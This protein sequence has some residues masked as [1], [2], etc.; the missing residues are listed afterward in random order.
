MVLSHVQSWK[1]INIRA[2]LWHTQ[3]IPCS[4]TLP[5][6]KYNCVLIFLRQMYWLC[7]QIH[8]PT[9]HHCKPHHN[10]LNWVKFLHRV[11]AH[12]EGQVPIFKKKKRNKCDN[13]PL[14]RKLLQIW[15]S[16]INSRKSWNREIVYILTL[17]PQLVAT[18]QRT[19]WLIFQIQRSEDNMQSN[20]Q[21]RM[22]KWQVSRLLLGN[23]HLSDNLGL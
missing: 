7:C 15:R 1:S 9:D 14:Q 11:E 13:I 8:F 2:T 12:F 17:K 20:P 22:L 21:N 10:S 19:P 18:S 3:K 23:L 5:N 4:S 16:I 6:I